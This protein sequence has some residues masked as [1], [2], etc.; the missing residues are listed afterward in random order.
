[1]LPN[2]V[3]SILGL[4]EGFGETEINQALDNLD[5]PFLSIIYSQDGLDLLKNI[6]LSSSELGDRLEVISQTAETN[7][8]RTTEFLVAGRTALKVVCIPK[9]IP[10]TAPPTD[11]ELLLIKAWVTNETIVEQKSSGDYVLSTGKTLLFWSSPEQSQDHASIKKAA[12]CLLG[13]S[14]DNSHIDHT[15]VWRE[16]TK[17]QLDESENWVSRPGEFHPQPLAE[18][19]VSLSTHPAPI[20]QPQADIPFP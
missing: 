20:I 14:E 9:E 18:P 5:R 4:E 16:N 12:E 3:S 1:M 6:A 15:E 19:D 17:F 8:W 2:Y 7:T 11:V 10:A 13:F